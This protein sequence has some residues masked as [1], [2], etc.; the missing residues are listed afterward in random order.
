MNILMNTEEKE[1]GNLYLKKLVLADFGIS[2]VMKKS[3]NSPTKLKVTGGFGHPDYW[4]PE[5][6]KQNLYCHIKTDVY[7]FGRLINHL[8]FSHNNLILEENQDG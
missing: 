1:P 6:R 2:S 4:A 7:S 5:V 3:T 8:F